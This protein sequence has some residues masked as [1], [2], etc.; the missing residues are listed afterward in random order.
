MIGSDSCRFDVMTYSKP[1]V[2]SYRWMA[3]VVQRDVKPSLAGN[4]L[5]L[6]AGWKVLNT[7]GAAKGNPGIAGGGGV[8][9]GDQGEWICGFGESMGIFAPL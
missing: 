1:S 6:P 8:L 4:H 9:R 5:R 2:R 3:M 7:D